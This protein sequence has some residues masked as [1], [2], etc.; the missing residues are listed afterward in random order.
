MNLK[1]ILTPLLAI[2]LIGCG[3]STSSQSNSSSETSNADTSKNSDTSGEKSTVD[4]YDIKWVTPTGAPTLPFYAEAKN[5]NWLSTSTPA[6]VMPQAFAGNSYDAIVFDGIS[7]LNLIRKSQ[8]ASHYALAR[9]INELPFYLVSTTHT[10]EETITLDHKIDAFVENGTAS[11][12]LRK[13]AKSNWNVGELTNVTYETGVSIVQSNLVRDHTSY[14][15]Y[16]LAEPVYTLTKANLASKGVTLNL[17]KDLQKEWSDNYEGAKIP[18][19]GL[20][21]NL[22]TLSAHESA[23]EEFVISFDTGVYNLVN[24]ASS[25][26]EDLLALEK[27]EEGLIAKQFGV[28]LPII[29]QLDKLQEENKLGFLDEMSLKTENMNYANLFAS[30]LGANEYGETLFASI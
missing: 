27:E 11:Q 8:G 15:Y 3:N 12:A 1:L 23:L 13:L 14:D 30:A 22:D 5:E 16:V 24:N 10:A 7:G 28:A 2:T 17:I 18:S 4:A 26:K 9:W 29:N 19:A 25:V 20:F 21:I 6:D